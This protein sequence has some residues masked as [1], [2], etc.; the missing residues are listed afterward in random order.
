MA[1]NTHVHYY[2][3]VSQSIQKQSFGF[4][5]PN[6]RFLVLTAVSLLD[7]EGVN[8]PLLNVVV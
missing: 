7:L 5:S 1:R 4:M 8:G 2:F 6:L 3:N